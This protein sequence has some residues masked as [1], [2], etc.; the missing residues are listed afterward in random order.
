MAQVDARQRAPRLERSRRDRWIAGVAGGIGH[1][2]GVQPSIVRIAFVVSSFAAGF[3]V[4]VLPTP[5][6]MLASFTSDRGF[7]A[8]ARTRVRRIP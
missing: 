7:E 1:H 3:G 4:V 2:L 6:R 8:M 5:D